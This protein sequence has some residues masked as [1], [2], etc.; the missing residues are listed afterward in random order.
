MYKIFMVFPKKG[1]E[2]YAWIAAESEIDAIRVIKEKRS[3]DINDKNCFWGFDLERVEEGF[4]PDYV[5]S[6]E[7][8]I[9]LNIIYKKKI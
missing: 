4:I 5:T 8:G 3:K 9:V 7:R 1:Y 6:S 2:G